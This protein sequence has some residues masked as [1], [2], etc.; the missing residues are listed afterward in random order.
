MKTI[1]VEVKL[2]RLEEL[3]E[4]SQQRALD[5]YV[6]HVGYSWFSE[7]IQSL[8]AF[9]KQFGI[10]V[11]DYC[12]GDVYSNR[13][14]VKTDACNDSFRGMRLRQF[15]AEKMPTGYFRDCDLAVAF[16]ENWQQT[17][18]ALSAF[19]HAIET[20]LTKVNRDVEESMTIESFKET[21]EANDWW[22]TESGKL[23]HGEV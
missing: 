18:S 3:S 13:N 12:I 15:D 4:D 6:N 19:N 8:E 16:R 7:D 20:F 11:R 17:G 10:M 14:Y 2:Y 1:N 21:C 23:Y 5:S 22:F 9:C